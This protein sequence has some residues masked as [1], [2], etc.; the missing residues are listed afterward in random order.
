MKVLLTVGKFTTQAINHTINSALNLNYGNNKKSEKN[1]KRAYKP[2]SQLSNIH[3]LTDMTAEQ[4]QLGLR[5]QMAEKTDF[6]FSN[7]GDGVAFSDYK[8]YNTDTKNNY[9]VA[10]RSVD[11]SLN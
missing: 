1:K 9:T 6:K 4:W 5:K 8:V 3:N 2:K 11:N 7:I 10:L